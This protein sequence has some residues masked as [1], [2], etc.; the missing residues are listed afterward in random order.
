MGAALYKI[1]LA[2]NGSAFAGYQRQAE[3]RTVQSELE[4]ALQQIGWGGS[5]VSAAGRTDAGVHARGQVV[6]FQLDWAHTT[7]DLRNA[8]NHYL[9]RDMSVRSVSEA[10]DG[11]HPRYDAKWRHYC[12]RIY[13]QPV[14]DPL[15]MNLAWQVWPGVRVELMNAAAKNLVGTHD[16]KAFGSA[17]TEGGPTV[18]EISSAVWSGQGDEWQFDI[19]ANAF[20]YHMVR[21]ITFTLVKI[22]Q[23][24]APASLITGGLQ[25]GELGLTGLAP[26]EG[27]VLEAVEY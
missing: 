4:G 10:P 6:S 8:L 17:M 9:P 22:G 14:R 24:E 21:R 15:R 7:E 20:L 18:R 27:L 3:A 26:A 2:Y 13:C 19:I 23:G 1:I 12:Y 16:F 5:H 11:F 25:S